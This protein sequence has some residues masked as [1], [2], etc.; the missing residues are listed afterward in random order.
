MKYM[1]LRSETSTSPLAAWFRGGF[2][3]K[4]VVVWGNET[5]SRA[6]EF[7]LRL[8]HHARRNGALHGLTVDPIETA[9]RFFPWQPKYVGCMGNVYNYGNG[10]ATLQELVN[11]YWEYPLEAVCVAH[12]DLLI[13]R[14][15]LLHDVCSD[16]M[17]LT[18]AKDLLRATIERIRHR[19]PQTAI[20]LTTENSLLL[21]DTRSLWSKRR[22]RAISKDAAQTYTDIL[23][24]AVMSFEGQY[25]NVAVLDL[26]ARLYGT[27]C[28]KRSRFMSDQF[29]PNAEGQ[30]READVIVEVIGR[31]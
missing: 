13:M 17:G 14:A 11:G 18:Q 20:L 6:A 23:H 10:S 31:Q 8:A 28:K 12:P 29:H 27:D 16:Q 26:M 7:F 22:N 4:T 21:R 19:S 3:G 30:R 1:N 25:P 5:V 15:P 2:F 9:P 24:D